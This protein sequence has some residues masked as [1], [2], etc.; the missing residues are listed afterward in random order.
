MP[1]RG[2][3]G[4]FAR[5]MTAAP[6]WPRP[7]PVDVVLALLVAGAATVD[8]ATGAS[9][10]PLGSNVLAAALTTLPLA[11]RSVAPLPVV[12][13][14]TWSYAL[15]VVLGLPSDETLIAPI[16]PVFAVYSLGEHARARELA[17]GV[18]AGLAAYVV[19]WVAGGHLGGLALAVPGV[20]GAAA[21]GRAVRV[22]GFETDVLKAQTV[23]AVADE[24]A[25]IARELHD[26]IGHSIA[27][28]GIEAGA[29]RR[30]LPAGL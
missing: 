19:A 10:A 9:D 27:V 25:R 4:T 1:M 23:E 16:A 26:V 11:W 14:T 6:P 29:V 21:V 8:A 13:V 5:E 30:V 7:E 15:A 18:L 2:G 28:M 3:A 12:V 24:R 22:M 20:L 17:G